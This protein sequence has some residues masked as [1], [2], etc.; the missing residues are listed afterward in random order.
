MWETLIVI[1]LV[2]AAAVFAGRAFYRIIAGKEE[3]CTGCTECRCHEQTDNGR[4]PD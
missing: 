2:G 3:K 4:Q 1:L